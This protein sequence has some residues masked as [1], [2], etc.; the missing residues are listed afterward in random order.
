MSSV[1]FW[2]G[3]EA[4][5]AR[6]LEAVKAETINGS[7]KV[8]ISDTRSKS[9]QARGIQWLW[10]TEVSRSGIGSRDTKEEVHRDA[11]YLFARPILMRD[12]ETF[13]EIW[14]EIEKACAGD[15]DKLAYAVDNFISTEGEGFA[16]GEFL[17]D[18]EHY[19]R[20]KGVNLTNP[21]PQQR[22]TILEANKHEQ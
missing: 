18:F 5:R 3:S 7:K 2:L 6:A 16:I 13:C 4:M 19:W 20:G 17:T 11:K 12:D 15:P 14:P 1:T 8:V 9:T 22:K 10:Y 21:D